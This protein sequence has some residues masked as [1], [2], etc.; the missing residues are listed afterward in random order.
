MIISEI[1]GNLTGCDYSHENGLL[2]SATVF[3]DYNIHNRVESEYSFVYNKNRPNK[4]DLDRL[5]RRRVKVTVEL[6]DE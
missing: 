2:L 3:G 1:K 4:I 5:M 6:L